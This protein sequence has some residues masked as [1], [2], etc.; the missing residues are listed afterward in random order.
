MFLRKLLDHPRGIIVC[1][2]ILDGLIDG[3]YDSDF[4]KKVFDSWE[5][6]CQHEKITDVDQKIARLRYLAFDVGM[7][8]PTFR[9]GV[10]RPAF[11]FTVQKKPSLSSNN[12][13]LAHIIKAHYLGSKISG[14]DLRRFNNTH[15]VTFPKDAADWTPDIVDRLQALPDSER[16]FKMRPTTKIHPLYLWYTR[17]EDLRTQ[18]N[19]TSMQANMARDVLGLVHYKTATPV[20]ALYFSHDEPAIAANYKPTFVEA[21]ISRRFKARAVSA[22]C[23]KRSAWGHAANLGKLASNKLVDGSPERIANPVPHRSKFSFE[24]LGLTSGAMGEP[25]DRTD[26]EYAVLLVDRQRSGRQRTK[27]EVESELRSHL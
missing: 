5:A 7:I 10:P 18:L 2:N 12:K 25:E 21:N 8:P 24:I 17:A 9:P 26:G 20:A 19:K 6:L 15:S 23:K 27:A 22:A 1:C 14:D 11:A 16:V 13:R 3:I 4:V